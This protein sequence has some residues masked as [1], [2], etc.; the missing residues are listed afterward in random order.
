MV[1]FPFPLRFAPVAVLLACQ[2]AASPAAPA[3]LTDADRAAIDS[4][5]TES[6]AAGV[7]GDFAKLA[8]L[9]AEDGSMMAPNAPVA[10]GRMAIQQ[11]LSAFPPFGEL[12]LIVHD[13]Y[14]SSEIAALRGTYTSLVAPPGSPAIADT[15]SYTE[16]WRKQADGKWLMAWMIWNS[17]KPAPI[18]Q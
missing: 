12:K 17:H 16:L 6:S 15:G 1:R 14:G 5:Q 2:Q 10:T 3:G 9:F 8:S 18:I 13:L 11:A 7:A 4:L